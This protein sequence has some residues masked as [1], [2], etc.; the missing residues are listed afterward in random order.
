MKCLLYRIQNKS[1][2]EFQMGSHYWKQWQRLETQFSATITISGFPQNLM[3]LSIEEYDC[4]VINTSITIR[5]IKC[6]K[7]W[8]PV[9]YHL[10]EQC[11]SPL[12]SHHSVWWLNISSVVSHTG[13]D[14]YIGISCLYSHLMSN[15]INVRMHYRKY[16]TPMCAVL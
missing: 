14:C 16:R 6:K 4:F 11:V 5:I 13:T 8:K 15:N 2:K 7:N 9:P 12:D 3:I 1:F 10:K